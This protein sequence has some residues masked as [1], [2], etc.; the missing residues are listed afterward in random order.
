[1]ELFSLHLYQKLVI[2]LLGAK[3][4]TKHSKTVAIGKASRIKIFFMAGFINIFFSKRGK[5]K[6]IAY[7]N[8]STAKMRPMSSV[9][10]LTA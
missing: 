4:V 10:K 2:L 1:M 5:H 3:I 7:K 8:Q 6:T 9:G